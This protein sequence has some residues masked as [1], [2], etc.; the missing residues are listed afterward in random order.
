MFTPSKSPGKA[1]DVSLTAVALG[2]VAEQDLLI[3]VRAAAG[4]ATPHR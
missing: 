1:T 3:V 4:V 2:A